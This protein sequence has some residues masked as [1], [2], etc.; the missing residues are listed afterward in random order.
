MKKILLSA[1]VASGLLGTNAFCTEDNSKI[2][3]KIIEDDKTVLVDEEYINSLPVGWSMVGVEHKISDMKMFNNTNTVW[4]YNNGWKA[5]SPDEETKTLIKNSG[6]SSFTEINATSG[7]WVNINKVLPKIDSFTTNS[8]DYD[9]D[10]NQANLNISTNILNIGNGE[11][12][13]YNNGDDINL[14]SGNYIDGNITL[15]SGNNNLQ[16]CVENS[17]DNIKVCKTNNIL[18][19]GALN[20]DYYSKI[21]LGYSS[22]ALTTYD[23]KIVSADKE[24]GKIYLYDTLTQENNEIFNVGFQVNGIAYLNNYFYI[25][26]T[27][28]HMIKNMILM[29]NILKISKVLTFQMVL[30]HIIIY[31]M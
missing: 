3:H 9:S 24:N 5:Y 27:S 19:E 7:F 17:T 16:V 10:N 8:M 4:I 21:E 18:I 2:L 23:N 26:N 15:P 28:N 22:L 12:K 13:F 29:E 14:S 25:T 31:F 30:E 20:I 11:I 6:I 1:V